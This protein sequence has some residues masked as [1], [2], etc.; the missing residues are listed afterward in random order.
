MVFNIF[1]ME[2]MKAKMPRSPQ[3]QKAVLIWR[4]LAFLVHNLHHGHHHHKATSQHAATVK[5]MCLLYKCSFKTRNPPSLLKRLFPIAL[6]YRL[7]AATGLP[8]WGNIKL[9]PNLIFKYYKFI[10]Y[11][12]FHKLHKTELRVFMCS[13]R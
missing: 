8:V 12:N 3:N 5:T 7:Q 9:Y 13:F 6:S 2:P 11:L 10:K 1:P 4:A